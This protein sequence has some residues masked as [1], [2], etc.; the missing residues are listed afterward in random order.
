V[1]SSRLPFPVAK[2]DYV[3]GQFEAG[4]IVTSLGDHIENVSLYAPKDQN[5]YVRLTLTCWDTLG[6]KHASIFDLSK[7][8]AW[9]QV[10]ILNDIWEDLDD[11][12]AESSARMRLGVP[13]HQLS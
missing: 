5:A 3:E 11:L 2:G 6:S 10:A 1:F 13:A 12:T 7:N 9:R 8:G 4:G